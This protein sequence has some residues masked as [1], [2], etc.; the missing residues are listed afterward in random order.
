MA[1]LQMILP[2]RRFNTPLTWTMPAGYALR[3]YR[4]GDLPAYVELMRRAGFENW[5]EETARHSVATMHPEGLFFITDASGALVAT[6]LAHSAPNEWHPEGGE[7]GW[8]GAAPEH[9]GKG[10]GYAVCAAA[11]RR[12]LEAGHPTIYLLTDD[13]RLPA[14]R[15]YLKLGFV[16]FL[17][18]P[19]MEGR[20]Q[21]VAKGLGVTLESLEPTTDPAGMNA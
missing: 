3:T 8:V 12:L 15:T 17:C 2:R 1:Q 20:W 13:P 18:L 21:A 5:S 11:T 19:D 6:A 10:L 7:L 14:I 9:R 16:P 4:E